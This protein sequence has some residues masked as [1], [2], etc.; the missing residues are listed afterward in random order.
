MDGTSGRGTGKFSAG[1]QQE[2]TPHLSVGLTYYRRINGGFL[3][4]DNT[5]TT[6]ADYTSYNLTLPTDSRLPLSGQ[7][8]TY[9][10]VNSVLNSGL[11]GLT[12]TNLNTYASNYGNWYQHWNG[13]D[14][15]GSSRLF[16]GITANGGVT[17][18][19]Q[20]VDNCDVVSKLPEILTT[21]LA[22]LSPQQL[23]RFETGWAPQVQ[24]ARVV[25]PAVA[26]HPR[27]R[28]P[29]KPAR[30]GASGLGALHA[31]ADHCG[32]RPGGDGGRQQ[33]G[34]R[35]RAVQRDGTDFGDRLNQ[36]DLRFSK[37]FK[38][39]YPPAGMARGASRRVS[40]LL[41][42]RG[43]KL[44]LH[45]GLLRFVASM[46]QATC[47]LTMNV[48][49]GT[50]LMYRIQVQGTSWTLSDASLSQGNRHPVEASLLRA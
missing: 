26:A 18:G 25:Y 30:A 35:N 23:C 1:I 3:V 43:C 16:A 14:I 48:S 37:I 6:A 5:A 36:L 50:V 40:G 44:N 31:G 21:P 33:V 4:T 12:T 11:S 41:C 29:A 15:T 2:L 20:M 42:R 8:L 46:F 9:H 45:R 22:G 17:F 24:G 10:D 34:A 32:P 49:P 47:L 19:Q 28:Q 38:A 27:Q 13:F 7:P 39:T